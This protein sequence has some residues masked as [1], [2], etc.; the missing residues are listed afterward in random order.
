MYVYIYM[1][2]M[3]SKTRVIG[4]FLVTTFSCNLLN[5][6]AK[7]LNLWIGKRPL[8]LLS[9]GRKGIWTLLLCV[10]GESPI[11]FTPISGK[12]W[13]ETS[14][15]NVGYLCLL[16]R[17]VSKLRPR[18]TLFNFSAVSYRNCIYFELL[19]LRNFATITPCYNG[20]QKH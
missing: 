11:N 7:R 14:V 18:T 5:N 15:P 8:N 3:L 13:N 12:Q 1:E 20:V 6:K 10:F 17:V 16:S 4:R 2:T 19:L 9:V